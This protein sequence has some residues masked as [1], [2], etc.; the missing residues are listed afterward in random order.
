SELSQFF[1]TA[2]RKVTNNKAMKIY[3]VVLED[4]LMLAVD[5]ATSPA[6]KRLIG[7]SIPGIPASL[8][9]W[10]KSPGLTMNFVKSKTEAKKVL[11]LLKREGYTVNNEDHFL[12]ELESLVVKRAKK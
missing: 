12:T 1:R 11:R 2:H 10:K 4:K 5:I 3:P 7:K 6:A 9:T 8:G